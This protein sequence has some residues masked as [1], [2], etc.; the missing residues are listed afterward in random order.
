MAMTYAWTTDNTAPRNLDRA[1]ELYLIGTAQ[2]N[3]LSRR[4]RRFGHIN[5]TTR[6]IVARKGIEGRLECR[7][8]E[9]VHSYL[10]H[11][12]NF[13]AEVWRVEWLSSALMNSGRLV[14]IGWI[15]NRSRLPENWR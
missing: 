12:M 9:T 8:I 13:S 7:D 4:V 1:G 6:Y 15:N 11:A 14:E 2:I 3:P 10:A 5:A